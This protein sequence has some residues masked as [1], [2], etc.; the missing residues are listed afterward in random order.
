MYIILY[1]S[2]YY[3]GKISASTCRYFNVENNYLSLSEYLHNHLPIA[4]IRFHVH[5]YN[6]HL[7]DSPVSRRLNQ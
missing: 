1:I 5:L 3:L 2:I 6:S 4:L 7:T